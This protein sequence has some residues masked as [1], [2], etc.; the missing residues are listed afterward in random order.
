[1]MHKAQKDG[2]N[3]NV[4]V[5]NVF[6]CKTLIYR[7]TYFYQQASVSSVDEERDAKE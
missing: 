1:M 2:G 6:G 5:S 3:F 4:F 7:P